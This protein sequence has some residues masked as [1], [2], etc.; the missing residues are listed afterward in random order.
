MKLGEAMIEIKTAGVDKVKKDLD[1]L[2]EKLE[3]IKELLIE[4]NGLFGGKLKKE[5]VKK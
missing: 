3:K 4:I 2:A 1:A 5:K